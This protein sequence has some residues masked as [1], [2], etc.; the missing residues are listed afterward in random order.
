[1]F[2]CKDATGRCV[3]LKQALPYVRLVGPE[4]PMTEDRARREANT[5]TAHTKV[6]PRH[7]CNLIDFDADNHALALEDL[8]DHEV[9]R[10]RLNDGGSHED[11]FE[12]LAQYVADV[13][14]GTSWYGVSEEDFRRA[15]A[16]A[17][18]PELC[19]I[20]EDLIFTEPFLGGGRNEFPDSI[21]PVVDRLQA[22]SE[23]IAAG[24]MMRHR[25]MSTQ[26]AHIHGD[27]HTGSVFVRGT[28]AALSVKAFDSE[29]AFYGPVGFDLGL[30]WANIL[31][32]AVRAAMLG[33]TDR[34]RRLLDAIGSSWKSFTARM[35]QNWKNRVTPEKYPDACLELWLAKILDDG[36][37]FAG[38]EA[39]RRT[40]GL[41]K[42]SDIETVPEDKYPTAATAMLTLGR[43]LVI[44]R[45]TRSFASY[46]E[47]MASTLGLH[48]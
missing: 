27:L 26:E 12:Q 1:M 43:S 34:S 46:L 38:C 18:N 10:T 40:V 22:D 20:T 21:A 5:I 42:L 7:V 30:M 37:G 11:I 15:A 33:E 36:L 32:A 24:M 2:I 45:S 48:R 19:N 16:A 4:W 17:I 23:W 8:T 41:A 25:F 28:G 47:E 13:A 6:S 31:A 3:V 14:M 9:L 29:F 35:R 39:T 44:D